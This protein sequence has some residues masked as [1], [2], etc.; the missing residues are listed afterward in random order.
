[1]HGEAKY[2]KTFSHFDYTS[3]AA[4]KGGSLTLF[5]LGTFDSLNGFIPKG[6]AADKLGLIYDSLTESSADEAFTQYGLIAEK[7][8][9]PVDRSWIIF[10]INPNARFHDDTHITAHDVVFTFNLLMQEGSPGYKFYY[11]DVNTVEALDNRRVKFSF[12]PNASKELAL[13]VGQL[14]VLPQHYWADKEFSKSGLDT[15]LGSG[16]YAIGKVDPGRS[17][18]YTR[19]DDYWAKNHPVRKN[20]HNFDDITIDYYRDDTVG[21][22]ALKAGE[23]DV[24]MERISR[25]WATAY[26]GNAIDEGRIIT[27]EIAHQ[28]P[29]GMQAYIFNTR[30]P[31]FKSRELRQA[32]SLAFDFE[33]ANRNIFYGAYKRTHSYFANSELASSKLPS[34]AELQLLAPYRED[35]PSALFDEVF[36][37]P[38]SNQ[39]DHNRSNLRQAKKILDAAGFKV[40]NNQLINPNTGKPVSFEIMLYDSG[41]ERVSNPFIQ[42]LKKLGIEAHLRVVDPS[43]YINRVKAFDFDMMVHVFSQSLSPGNEQVDMWHSRSAHQKGSR[44]LIGVEHSVVDALVQ[45]IV[46]A[47]SREE[48]ITATKALDRVLLNNHYVIPQWHINYHRIAYWNKFETP[49]THPIYDNGYSTGLMTWWSK[50]PSHTE[51]T[52]TEVQ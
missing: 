38:K 1:M 22:E 50:N 40:I 4:Q 37:L 52:S 5:G 41:F 48:L 45:Y 3:D 15:P 31:H 23:Y 35:L 36:T 26:T 33:W 29:S 18:S 11:A 28:N 17:I 39:N 30:R 8:E 9:Y 19:V 32:I 27:R 20:T 42:G 2:S 21:I 47:K 43:Q 10:H 44:N 16:P 34:E 14:P 6:N 51:P 46:E 7:M 24:R 25:F 13:T 49:K 12:K